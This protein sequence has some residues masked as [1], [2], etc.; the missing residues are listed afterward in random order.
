VKPDIA[1]LMAESDHWTDHTNI[2]RC[3]KDAV[4]FAHGYLSR[5][6]KKPQFMLTH[7][8][9]AN[10]TFDFHPDIFVDTTPVIDKLAG[11]L[12]ELHNVTHEGEPRYVA[13]TTLFGP[14]EKGFPKKLDLTDYADVLL[15]AN[16]HI[17]EGCGARYAEAFQSI[18]FRTREIW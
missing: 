16:R 8:V 18:Q 3:G 14:K 9:G 1:V 10:Q 5:N 6:V 4:L 2:A 7:A 13:Q 12:N 15:A 11:V 17:G